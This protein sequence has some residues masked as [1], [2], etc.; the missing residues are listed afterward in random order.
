MRWILAYFIEV[1][2]TWQPYLSFDLQLESFGV[3]VQ[4]VG[5]TVA[6]RL[7]YAWIEDWEEPL[8]KKNKPV[9]Q[10]RLKVKYQNQASKNDGKWFFTDYQNQANKALFFVDYENQADL[11]I[12][13]V[14]YENQAGWKNNSKRHLMY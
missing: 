7:F 14:S 9:A 11:K 10:A 8:L 13:F 2:C 1:H 4:E 6:R 3:D 5:Q 12:F